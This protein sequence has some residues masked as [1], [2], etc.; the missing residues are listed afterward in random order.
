MNAKTVTTVK[1]ALR[2]VPNKAVEAGA[3]LVVGKALKGSNVATKV[4]AAIAVI[5]IS[6][7]VIE[8]AAKD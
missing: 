7:Y 3:A 5:T 8:W 4:V 6:H 1:K 2:K